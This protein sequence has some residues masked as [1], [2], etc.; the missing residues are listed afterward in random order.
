[1]IS[2]ADDYIF[3]ENFCQCPLLPGATYQSQ[4]SPLAADH[5]TEKLTFESFKQSKTPLRGRE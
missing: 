4:S 3:D 5:V 2:I 1:M